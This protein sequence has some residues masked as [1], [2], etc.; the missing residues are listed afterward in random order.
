MRNTYIHILF[1]ITMICVASCHSQH[2]VEATTPK[3]SRNDVKFLMASPSTPTSLSSKQEHRYNELFLE[4]IR[5]KEADHIDAEYELLSAALQINP[6]ASEAVYEMG[7]LKLSYT[8]FSDT[9][10]RAQGDSL[11]RQAVRL[12]PS[13]TYYK[14]TLASFL[15][16]SAKYREAIEL[17]EEIADSKETEETLSTLIWL[18]KTSGD[19][20]GAIR[21]IERLERT[22]GKSEQLSMEKFQTYIAMKDDEHA[23]QA[24]ED[25]CAEYPYDLRYRVLLGDLYDQNGYHE[26]ALYIYKDVLTAEPDNSYAQISL[27]AYY[28]AACA[29]S[30]YLD[31]LQKVVLNPHTQS[32]AR[33]EAMRAYAV[34]NLKNG[35]DSTAVLSLFKKVLQSP[36][37]SRDMAELYAYYVIEKHMPTDSILNALHC[38]LAVEPDYTKARLLE[39]QILLQHDNMEEVT[40]ACREGE[41]YDPREVTFYYYEGTALYR[42]GRDKEAIRQL[43]RGTDRIDENTD[44]Q[45]ASDIYAL[46]GDVLHECGYKEDAYAAYEKSL[47]Y[48]GLNALCLNNYAYFLSLDGTNLAK[49]EQMSKQTIDIKPDDP[50]FLDTYAWILFLQ[51][52]YSMARTYIEEALRFTNETPENVSIFDHAGDIAFRCGNRTQALAYWKKAL[53]LSTDKTSRKRIQRKIGRRRI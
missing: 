2:N 16:N 27:L 40:K 53:E 23:Y 46:L 19:Y 7:V 41:L 15:A 14:E 12:A 33:M 49:A 9:L 38:I 21:T 5:Q 25:L 28:K 47:D 51:R 39:L 37:E 1:F 4:A 13:N 8:S 11:L 44:R 43:Q 36:Q 24:I 34:D 45:L 3:I 17:Y 18:Y 20:A 35:G 31:L 22:Q 10:S 32:G 42:L 48:N 6:C 30:L 52:N 29:D 50:T 26:Q